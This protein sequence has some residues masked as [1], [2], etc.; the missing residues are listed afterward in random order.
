MS[1]WPDR[2]VP[3][4]PNGCRRYQYRP[5]RARCLGQ[6][7]G[8]VLGTCVGEAAGRRPGPAGRI[9]QFRKRDDAGGAKTACN[10]HPAVGQQRRRMNLACVGEAAGCRPSSASRIVQFRARKRA[11]TG[12]AARDEHLAV[13]QQGRRMTLACGDEAAGCRPS[14]AGRIV[15]FRARETIAAAGSDSLSAG[16]ENLPVGKQGRRLKIACEAQITGARPVLAETGLHGDQPGA[17]QEQRDNDS[18]RKNRAAEI[19]APIR[20]CDDPHKQSFPFFAENPP[21]FPA[22]REQVLG[23]PDRL[24]VA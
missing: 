5:R 11:A 17:E 15:Q 4:S 18:P 9:V 8:R 13:G 12:R 16:D 3:H 14:P 20:Q 10:E 24:D 6:Q 23:T 19:R 22:R 21:R 1:H 2:T 7:C